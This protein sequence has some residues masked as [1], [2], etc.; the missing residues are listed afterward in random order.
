MTPLAG[1]AFVALLAT[2]CGTTYT[3][4]Y[5]NR[6]SMVSGGL[7]RGGVIFGGGPFGGDFDQA[8]MGVP[9]AE[10]EMATYQSEQTAGTILWWA[11]LFTAVTGSTMLEYA[12][13][14]AVPDNNLA[15]GYA[16]GIT[17]AV[18]AFVGIFVQ[19]AARSHMLDAVNIFNDTAAPWSGAPGD[20]ARAP[21]PPSLQP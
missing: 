21:Q 12:N 18:V 19:I 3:P 1:L 8:V 6:I 15:P 2:A 11:G 14:R 20:P 5:S 16:V 4:A 13:S 10:A 7:E 17:G 9:R